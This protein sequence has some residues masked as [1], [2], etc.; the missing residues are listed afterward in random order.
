MREIAAETITEAIRDMCIEANY[1]LASDMK[2]SLKSSG[3]GGIPSG[4]PGSGPA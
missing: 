3:G 2:R 1:G 4:P